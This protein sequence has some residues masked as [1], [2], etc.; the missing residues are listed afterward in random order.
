MV[1]FLI[2]EILYE[3]IKVENIVVKVVNYTLVLFGVEVFKLYILIVRIFYYN[4]SD[5][6]VF[7]RFVY[8][9]QI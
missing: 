6:F 8:L 9:K 1:I 7:I 4:N 3:V 2:E 5:N